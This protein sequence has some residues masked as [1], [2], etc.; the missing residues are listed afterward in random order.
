MRGLRPGPRPW[1]LATAGSSL[2]LN[3]WG[4][5]RGR[6][7]LDQWGVVGSVAATTA[8]HVEQVAW[9][10]AE[11]EWTLGPAVESRWITEAGVPISAGISL[12]WGPQGLAPL[13]HLRLQALDW[14]ALL[15]AS[16]ALQEVRLDR[17][18][19]VWGFGTGLVRAPDML[20]AQGWIQSPPLGP[21]A[22]VHLGWSGLVDLRESQSLSQGPVL[23]VSSPCDCLDLRLE[24]TWTE[25]RSFPLLGLKLDIL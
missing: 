7:R 12:P 5:G 10:I 11:P 22:S 8:N 13:G 6:T 25:D 24:A 9:D 18:D 19:A 1:A 23:R 20:Q 15:I 17:R 14:S 16:D 3:T 4:S 21:K 2:W